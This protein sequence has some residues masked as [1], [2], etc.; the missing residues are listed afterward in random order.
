MSKSLFILVI[1]EAR[2]ESLADQLVRLKSGRI[3]SPARRILRACHAYHRFGTPAWAL[4]SHATAEVSQGC[5]RRS[6]PSFVPK[7]AQQTPRVHALF[8]A[9]SGAGVGSGA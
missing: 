8:R 5:V 3:G 6:I 9:Y 2:L 1:C 4:A 7:K